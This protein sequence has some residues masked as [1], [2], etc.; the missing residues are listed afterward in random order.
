MKFTLSWL[1]DHLETDASLDE[2]TEAMVRVGLEVE[3]VHD[4]AA[5]LA[6]ISVGYVKTAE[7]H[8]DA[9]KLQVCSVETKDGTQQIVCGAPN[10][11]AGI[12]VAYAPVGAYVPGIDTTLTK[13]K[14]RGV[15]SLGML[16]S[17]REL[18]LGDEHDGIMELPADAEVGAPLT[19][20]L[21]PSDPVIDFEV[22]PNRP[23]TNGV[24]GVARDLAAAGLGTLKDES[25]EPVRG[26]FAQPVPVE[27][28]DEGACPAFASRLI[29]G[30]KNGPSPKWLQDRLRAIGLRPINA[31][32]DV[33]NFLTH[34]RARPLH[35]YDAAKI[36]GTLRARMGRE[37]EE[38]DALDGKAYAVTPDMCVIADDARVLGLGGVMG[39]EHS[40]SEEDTT[41][42]LIECALFDPLRTA[43]TGRTTGITSDARYRFERGVDP[44]SV[45]P[46]IE[47]ATRLIL[48]MCGGEPSEVAVAGRIP[49]ERATVAFPP[50]EVARL[51]GLNVAEDEMDRI[52]TALGFAVER[53]AGQ[54]T[55]TVP[56][57]RPDV[58][59]KADLVEEVARIVGLDDLPAA[60]LPPLQPVQMARLDTLPAR[61]R[62]VRSALANEGYLE[63]V[64][65]AFTDEGAAGLF[66]GTDPGLK[67]ANPISSD[68]GV[69]RPSPLPNLLLAVRRNR[70][71]GAESVALFELGGAY[72]TDK[73]DGQKAVACGVLSG[74]GPRDWRERR[75]A[76]DV[77]T[78]K[79]H[80]LL[81]L[82]AAGVTT[83]NL[84]TIADG[85][86]HY[87][88]GRK[89]RL[90]LG[91]KL[92]L[93]AFGEVHPGVLAAMDVPGPVAA[94]EVFLDRVPA[95]R[96][97]TT[98]K[99]AL[100]ASDLMPL[101]RDFAFVVE[102]GVSA[103]ALIRAVR[104]AEKKL[105]SDVRLFD[106]YEG[107]GVPQ[108]HKSLAIEVVLQPK[109][110]TLTEEDIE[111]VS[112][113][114]VAA[115]GKL[116]AVQ[117]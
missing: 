29:R 79:A 52:L 8:P 63:A 94:F 96:S 43:R 115:A 46:G 49:T 19:D 76:P 47:L 107:E 17:V 112:G 30:V 28:D 62:A 68:L 69:M 18:E 37:G 67:L 34:D 114:I 85:P 97:K 23:D 60:T 13:A 90:G 100:G 33:T 50:S 66:G 16:C 101:R 10:A 70:A 89:G 7:R 86:D 41:D 2:I 40:G 55:V 54:W 81:A 116:G 9:D 113:R 104:G 12:K 91:P 77:F 99:P 4:P 31:L 59:H 98:A 36:T 38:L 39:G 73:P 61:S 58:T 88:P 64:T 71:R 82:E 6:P 48:D 57:A 35:V 95:A 65:W 93:A 106:L 84:M 51:T 1:K 21:G 80:A 72:A 117:R 75:Q 78:A 92:I 111:A 103:E 14:I 27:I 25:V 22:T 5:A 102:E 53:G 11:R 83:A 32:V 44:A 15:E 24:D 20:V 110:R 87:H 42:V 109:D 26:A 3:D 74:T 108:G 105:V 45:L 56:T